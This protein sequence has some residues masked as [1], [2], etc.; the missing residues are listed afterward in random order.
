VTLDTKMF[1]LRTPA[2]LLLEDKWMFLPHPLKRGDRVKV[3]GTELAGTVTDVPPDRC[4][5]VIV[6]LDNGT[7]GPYRVRQLTRI[8]Q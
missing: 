2:H 5:E 8:A 1:S 6:A 4:F 7:T 3:Q